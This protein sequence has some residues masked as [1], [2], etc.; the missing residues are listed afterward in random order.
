M[1][2]RSTGVNLRPRVIRCAPV[3]APQ[4][5]NIPLGGPA[6]AG[7]VAIAIPAWLLAVKRPTTCGVTTASGG[8]CGRKVNGVIFGCGRSGHTWV[9]FLARFGWRRQPDPNR[10][11]TRLDGS[12]ETPEAAVMTVKIAEDW[13]ST[14][15]FWLA[16]TATLCGLVSATVDATAF[17]KEHQSSK[18]PAVVAH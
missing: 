7:S 11:P 5:S 8:R 1:A 16:L 6:W 12:A 13:K 15:T 9:K 14:V 18:P 10:P 4:T 17:I 2:E 3:G